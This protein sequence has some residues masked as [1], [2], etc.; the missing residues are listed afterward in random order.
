[1]SL[2]PTQVCQ[3]K[4]DTECDTVVA[5]TIEKVPDKECTTL[6]EN[7]CQTVWESKFDKQCT[8]TQEQKCETKIE[9]SYSTV[10]E[11]KCNDVY[12]DHCQG[13]TCTNVAISSVTYVCILTLC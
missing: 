5:T 2:C 12:E 9:T 13:Y 1:L 7:K 4:F 6:T 3:T 10:Y 8:T 11:E